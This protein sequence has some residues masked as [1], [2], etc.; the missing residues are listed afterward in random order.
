[1]RQS[2]HQL[3]PPLSSG[4]YPQRAFELL[5]SLPLVVEEEVGWRWKNVR[6]VNG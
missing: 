2:P 3:A 5:Q 4:Q 1:V 6:G